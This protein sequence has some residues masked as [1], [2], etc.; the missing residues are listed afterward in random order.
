M[1]PPITT[2]QL[3]AA[4]ESKR[5]ADAAERWRR[6]MRAERPA[7]GIARRDIPAARPQHR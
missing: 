6:M 2:R 3:Q 1:L 4:I 5:R 7:A